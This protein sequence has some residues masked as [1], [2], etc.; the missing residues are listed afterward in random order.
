MCSIVNVGRRT[1][2]YV[3]R[4]STD[5][6]STDTL[7]DDNGSRFCRTTWPT[8]RWSVDC[9]IGWMWKAACR[10]NINQDQVSVV[11]RWYIRVGNGKSETR[12]DAEIEI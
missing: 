6:Q 2:R 4:Y 7:T 10:S 12:R 5:T 11:Y 3:G 8:Y 1:D 9:Y